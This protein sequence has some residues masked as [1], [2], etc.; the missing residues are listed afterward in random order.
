MLVGIAEY[1]GAIEGAID[2]ALELLAQCRE[3]VASLP[4]SDY[5]MAMVQ[6]T[7]FLAGL[8]AKCR[9]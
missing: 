9:M 1:E 7:W 8:L 3:D 6:I 5:A 4:E 2:T